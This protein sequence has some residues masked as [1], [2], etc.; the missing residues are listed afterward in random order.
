MSMCRGSCIVRQI[1]VKIACLFDDNSMRFCIYSK[2]MTISAIGPSID[3][4][5]DLSGS[6]F[7]RARIEL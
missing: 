2:N 7:F 1:D 6:H 5:L 3:L 4:P